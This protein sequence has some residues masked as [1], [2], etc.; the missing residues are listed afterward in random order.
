MAFMTTK[1]QLYV[2]SR[3]KL[4]ASLPSPNDHVVN[5]TSHIS[6]SHTNDY[7]SP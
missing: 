1:I 5:P 6:R 3:L 4:T 7:D 2:P